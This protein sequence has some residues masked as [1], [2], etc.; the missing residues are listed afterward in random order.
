MSNAMADENKPVPAGIIRERV[1]DKAVKE[2]SK[3]WLPKKYAGYKDFMAGCDTSVRQSLA[4]PKRFGPDPANWTWGRVFVARFSHPL[5]VATLIGGQ[6]SIPQVPIAGSGQTPNVGSAVSM[7]LITSPGNWDATRHVI[8]LGES[9]DPK[10][11][12]WKDQFEAWQKGIPQ[13]F[14]F[15]RSAIERAAKA[16][17]DYSPK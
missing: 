4:D 16:K 8:P 6:F 17:M 11:A 9:G 7:R 14:P 10:S 13:I 1:V 3:L 12:H 15:T 2:Q 5:S